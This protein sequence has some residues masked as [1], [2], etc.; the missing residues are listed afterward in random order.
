MENKTFS[1]SYSAAETKEVETIRRKYVP[2]EEDKLERLRRLDGEVAGAG[3]L[4]SLCL[5]V[6]GVLIFGIAMCFGLG[7]F[8]P[9]WWPAFPIGLIGIALMLPAWPLYRH[10]YEKKKQELTPEILKLTEELSRK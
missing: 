10:L 8:G 5:G 9:V 2:H 4:E 3:V 7:V 6:I 1:Y